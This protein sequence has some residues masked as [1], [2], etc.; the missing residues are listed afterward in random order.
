MIL[1]IT[2]LLGYLMRL[3]TTLLKIPGN[4]NDGDFSETGFSKYSHWP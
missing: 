4:L 3:K 2:L 1:I